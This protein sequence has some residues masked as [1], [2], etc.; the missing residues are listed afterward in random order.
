ML[1]RLLLLFCLVPL[2]ELTLLLW[3]AD[4]TG[5]RATLLLVLGTGVVGAALARYQ[6]WQVVQR[7][8][9]Q[10]EQGQLPADSLLDGLMIFIAGALLL[11]PGILTDAVGFALLIPFFRRRIRRYLGRRFRAHWQAHSFESD[12]SGRY[13]HNDFD[14]PVIDIRPSSPQ[15]ETNDDTS[16]AQ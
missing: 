14:G 3:L 11:T 16:D 4:V 6:G 7:I 15:S 5:W 1:L 2:V 9:S 10:L 13:G 8:Q 12:Y